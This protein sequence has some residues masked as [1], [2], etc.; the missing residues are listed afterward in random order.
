M[1][2]AVPKHTTLMF[3]QSVRDRE[4]ANRRQRALQRQ[5]LRNLIEELELIDPETF[6]RQVELYD[7]THLE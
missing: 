7:L 5:R 2:V 3:E 4:R 1:L 6:K